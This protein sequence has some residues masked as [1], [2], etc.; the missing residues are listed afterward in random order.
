MP[1]LSEFVWYYNYRWTRTVYHLVCRQLH[2]T[3]PVTGTETKRVIYSHTPRIDLWTFLHLITARHQ[4]H[5]WGLRWHLSSLQNRVSPSVRLRRDRRKVAGQAWEK[6]EGKLQIERNQGLLRSCALQWAIKAKTGEFPVEN[7]TLCRSNSNLWSEREA[8]LVN[9]RIWQSGAG[10]QG[11]CFCQT[12]GHDAAVQSLF[13]IK[14]LFVED[15]ISLHEY[16][17]TSW[18]VKPAWGTQLRRSSWR[19]KTTKSLM[20]PHILF[21]KE[22]LKW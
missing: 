17:K 2:N 19:C 5:F 9:A 1:T 14:K 15:L 8:V 7:L 12:Q 16:N 20:T 6:N 10:T 11:F 18:W 22:T 3:I 4:S 13:I 21:D